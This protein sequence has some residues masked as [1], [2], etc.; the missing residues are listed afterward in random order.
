MC[1]QENHK[2]QETNETLRRRLRDTER[3]VQTL[4]T[5]LRRNALHRVEEDS[6]S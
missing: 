1:L 3:E 4:Q 6:S 5:L 2:L